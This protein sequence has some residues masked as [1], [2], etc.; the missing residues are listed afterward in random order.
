MKHPALFNLERFYKK[1]ITLEE[2]TELNNK[3]V[4]EVKVEKPAIPDVVKRAK[5]I[6]GTGNACPK[7][8]DDP[9][10]PGWNY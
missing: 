7:D 9:D 10:G 1:E 2:L 4:G 3:L 6:F 8:K 5:D